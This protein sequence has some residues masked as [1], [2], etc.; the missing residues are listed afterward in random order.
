VPERESE[1]NP[2]PTASLE[3]PAGVKLL[4]TLRGSTSRIGRIAWSLDG[5]LASPAVDGTIRLLDAETGKC[6]R[7]I[8]G[9]RGEVWGVAFDPA[10]RTLASGSA[11]S[12]IKLWEPTSGRL[13]HTLRGHGGGV[14]AV[15]FDPSGHILASAGYGG[16]VILWEVES[17]RLLRTLTGHR[18][19]AWSVAFDPAGL[20]L[21]TGGDDNTVKLWDTTDGRLLR[22]L[23]VDASVLSVVFDPHGHTLAGACRGGAVNMWD[24]DSGQ[25]TRSL[26]GHT[27]MV[28][29]LGYSTEHRLLATKGFHGDNTIRV[30]AADGQDCVAVIPEPSALWVLSGLAFHPRLPLLATVGS[31]PGS[32]PE[33]LDCVIHIW[34]LDPARLLGHAVAPSDRYTSAK[35]VLVGDS[36]VG[37][38]GLGWRLAHGSFQ[39][40]AS[41][42]G[43]QF[44]LL[45]QLDKKRADGAQCEAILWDLAGQQDYRL[46]HAL[47][48]DDAD[49]ALVLFDPCRDSDPLHGVEFW[50]RQM[51]VGRAPQN[52]QQACPT[53][54]VAARADRGTAS[55]TTEEIEEFC[56]QHGLSGYV[57]TS[58]RSGEGVEELILRTQ[59]L[60]PWDSKPATVT[61]DAFRR[62]K[63]HVLELKE[64]QR[65]GK[66]VLTPSELRAR[67]EETD[68]QWTFT[69]AELL[70]AAGHLANHGYV[71]R[72]KTSQGEVR[73]LLAP[74]LLNNLA[75]SFV[76]EARRQEKGLGSLEEQRL[77]AGQ[78]QFPELEKLLPDER[79]I[80]LDSAA[81]LFLDHN[82]CF[83]ETDPLTSLT[84]LVFPELINLKRPALEE[85]KPLEDG[86]AYAV[87]GSVENVYASLVV[88]LGYTHTFTRTNQWQKQA[89]Y[90]VGNRLIC[91]FR[92]E[93]EREG[94][95][96]FVLSFGTDVSAPIRTLFQSL[97]ESFMTRRNLTVVR[98]EPVACSKRHQVNRAVVRQQVAAGID[99][100]FCAECGEKVVLP[101]G[102]RQIQLTRS[103]SVEVETQ[104]RAADQRSRFEQAIYR[105]SSYITE[106]K[107]AQPECFISY[108]WGNAEQERWV[109][110]S[111]ATDLL[112]AGIKVVLDRWENRRIGANVPRFVEKAGKCDRVIVVGTPLYRTKYENDDP[113]RG[114][115]AAAEG[116]L[117]GMRM[118]GTEAGKEA[119]LPVLLEGEPK[120]AFPV[121]LL[122]RVYADFRKVETY[123]DTVFDLILSV[124]RIPPQHT[125]AEELRNSLR[126]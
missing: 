77:L 59:A 22:T 116:E 30:W 107:I 97:F 108:A 78:Y 100:V 63:D 10:G 15:A 93:G 111:L 101:K 120:D 82:I 112:Q 45:H 103:Q 46:I 76:L 54:L 32:P 48:L 36:G 110:Y 64:N 113:K 28:N 71:T 83:R 7:T 125:V 51:Q 92:Q 8:D 9:H 44:W 16:S 96:Q 34:E 25:F 89:R 31:D 19:L 104:R 50:L 68:R 119:V 114:Y 79:D 65:R 61:T 49:L 20:M 40:H 87:A 14:A 105:W 37:K 69:D 38:T 6:L 80:L 41:T 13:L 27:N 1:G 118:L 109:E 56:R 67:L 99:F 26:D 35:I 74:E 124:Y 94:E 121:M 95:L 86:V 57:R 52:G 98:Y 88:L 122:G 58:A 91:G 21:A 17:G 23:N 47:F 85:D 24:P 53:I 72:L 73:I 75:A 60:I 43:Q 33:L 123:F 106:Q 4:R 70:T 39:E 55:L 81:V 84:Y 12:T 117:I 115:V 126:G 5:R 66:V 102:D 11:D 42:H 29:C 3:L 90:E 62:I 18:G 2:S